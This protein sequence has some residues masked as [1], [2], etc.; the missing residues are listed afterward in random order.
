MNSVANESG[1]TNAGHQDKILGAEIHGLTLR[2]Q[3]ELPVE[4]SSVQVLYKIE[5]LQSS[6]AAIP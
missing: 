6:G 4:K 1:P 2:L 5:Y 3:E